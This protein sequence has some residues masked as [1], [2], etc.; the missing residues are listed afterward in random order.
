MIFHSYVSLPKGNEQQIWCWT[1]CVFQGFGVDPSC[2]SLLFRQLMSW[3]RWNFVSQLTH[4]LQTV[5][6]TA[7]LL[8]GNSWSM[9]KWRKHP[10]LQHVPTV[11]YCSCAAMANLLKTWSAN[12]RIGQVPKALQHRNPVPQSPT[13]SDF[14]GSVSQTRPYNCETSSTLTRASAFW[15]L[16]STQQFLIIFANEHLKNIERNGVEW[17]DFGKFTWTPPQTSIR[18]DPKSESLWL[19]SLWSSSS[20]R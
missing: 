9:L 20:S 6:D 13:P 16:I 3:W 19:S 7:G 4:V 12:D 10:D 14:L 1:S 5:W 2:L 17:M 15:G 11:Q 18:R 8:L